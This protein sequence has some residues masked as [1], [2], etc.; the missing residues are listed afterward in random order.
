M[1]KLN[2]GVAPVIIL[3]V[4]CLLSTAL[5]AFTNELTMEKRE[6]NK[7]AAIMASKKG[8]FPEAAQFEDLQIPANLIEIFSMANV[9]KNE[10]GEV[11]GYLVQT[12]AKGYG[13]KVN[14]LV[15]FDKD[16][17]VKGID[18]PDQQETAGLGAKIAEP[19][20]QSQFPGK[21]MAESFSLGDGSGNT[22]D[23]ISGATISSTA[24]VNA[25]NLSVENLQALLGG[26]E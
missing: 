25:L 11:L 19:A 14:A 23:A 20:F 24:V 5:L 7:A 18:F 4:I 8:I 2:E 17:K 21:S 6:A 12:S 1:K 15:G 3:C 22:V 13:G 16:Y 10:A 9:A 26:K